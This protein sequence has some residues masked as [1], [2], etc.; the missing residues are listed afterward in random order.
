MRDHAVIGCPRNAVNLG[1]E[2]TSGSTSQACVASDQRAYR[3]CGY[4][5]ELLW[6]PASGISKLSKDGLIVTTR[7]KNGA[8]TL[9]RSTEQMT[10]LDIY[11]A[12]AAFAIHNYPVEK[13]C[14]ISCNVSPGKAGVWLGDLRNPRSSR[15]FPAWSSGPAADAVHPAKASLV[16]SI[17][18]APP[19]G[20]GR[21]PEGQR[22]AAP[23]LP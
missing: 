5:N 8:S 11:R 2:K 3:P 23:C 9:T 21:V 13:R 18:S 10:L 14:P 15:R 22:E 6:L 17:G 4:W 7:G 16:P 1:H 20:A 12:S 19:K